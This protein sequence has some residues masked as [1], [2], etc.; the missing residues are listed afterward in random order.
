MGDTVRRLLAAL[1]LSVACLAVSVAAATPALA[2]SPH[3]VSATASR[4]G[5]TLTV[6]FK[7]A[8]LGNDDQTVTL[9]A[10]AQCFNKGGNE[11]Q[12][13]NKGAI[14]ATGTFSPKNGNI[15]G[16]LSGSASTDPACNPPMDLRYA[17]VTITDVT[18]GIS[19][20]FQG[21]F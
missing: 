11:P 15:V 21:T 1:A 7:L 10:D 17:N 13:E 6:N 5:D 4:I 20:T 18:A 2:G 9:A 16:S 14:L 19:Y 3:F 12:A 8:G